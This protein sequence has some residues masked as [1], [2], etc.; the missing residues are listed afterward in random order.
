[1]DLS[2][3]SDGYQLQAMSVFDQQSCAMSHH[4]TRDA[5]NNYLL[6]SNYY[7]S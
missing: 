2:D 6:S 5:T 3:L 4:N 7:L 1:M